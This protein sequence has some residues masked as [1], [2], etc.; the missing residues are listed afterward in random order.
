MVLAIENIPAAESIH[1]YSQVSSSFLS[2]FLALS[3]IVGAE[4][5]T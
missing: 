1:P 2:A 5:F 3:D 4:F